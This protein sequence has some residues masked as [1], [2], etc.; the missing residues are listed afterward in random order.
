M[1]RLRTRIV[2]AIEERKKAQEQNEKPRKHTASF[3]GNDLRKSY[4]QAY[5][6]TLLMASGYEAILR[7]TV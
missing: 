2:K 6:R 3:H 5:Y 4:S 7:R 1:K